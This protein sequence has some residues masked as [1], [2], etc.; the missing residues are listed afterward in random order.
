MPCDCCNALRERAERRE[1]VLRDRAERR[2]PVLRERA[3][4]REPVLRKRANSKFF[5]ADY[6]S[7]DFKRER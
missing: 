5:Q 2:E 7:E 1:L 4:R 3:E 6:K